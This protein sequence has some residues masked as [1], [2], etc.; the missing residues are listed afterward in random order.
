MTLEQAVAAGAI[1]ALERAAVRCRSARQ[2]A[3]AETYAELASS[4]K[5]DFFP[6]VP[7]ST[8]PVLPSSPVISGGGVLVEVA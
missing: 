6:P 4:I 7:D 2:P 3:F 5:D 8:V 1:R